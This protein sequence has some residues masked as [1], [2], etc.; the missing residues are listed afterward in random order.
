MA[1]KVRTLLTPWAFNAH[2]PLENL[3]HVDFVYASHSIEHVAD[4]IHTFIQLDNSVYDGGYVFLETP[5][6]ADKE[7]LSS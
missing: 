1:K 7:I 2:R 6:V 5:N 4:L 3:Q